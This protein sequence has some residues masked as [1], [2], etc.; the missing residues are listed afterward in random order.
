MK[1]LRRRSN[2]FTKK[3]TIYF[4]TDPNSKMVKIGI[5]SRSAKDRLKDIAPYCP[6][7]LVIL[8]T[9]KGTYMDEKKL[10]DK[11]REYHS[12]NEWFYHKGKLKIFIENI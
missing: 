12:H 7:T 1:S 9:M 10:H 3:E 8:K 5:T 6:V 4:I 11:F 2:Y